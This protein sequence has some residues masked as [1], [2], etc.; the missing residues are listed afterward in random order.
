MNGGAG[1]ARGLEV[2]H[3]AVRTMFGAG[4][5]QRPVNRLFAQTDGQQRLLFLLVH[6]SHELLDALCRCGLRGHRNTHWIAQE[7]IAQF[8]NGLG[9][10]G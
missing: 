9:H 7:T 4:K 2:L 3:H 6:K 1:D 10:G 8:G 5:D